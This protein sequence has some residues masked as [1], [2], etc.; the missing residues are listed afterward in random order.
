MSLIVA[1][2]AI[3][4]PSLAPL[5]A[6]EEVRALWVVRTSLTSRAAIETMVSAA[7][8]SGFNTL[9]V[10][11][12]G[13]ADAYYTDGLEPRASALSSQPAFDPLATTLLLAH[14]AGLQ[15]HALINVNLVAGRTS[16]RPR[17]IT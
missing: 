12:R 16:C 4:L 7:R 13:R 9:L 8:T 6:D 14:E 3:S 17:A 1:A 11:I 5:R 15:V 2:L 10:Q